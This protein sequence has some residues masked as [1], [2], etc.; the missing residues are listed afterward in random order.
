MGSNLGHF[1]Q[2]STHNPTNTSRSIL[3]KTDSVACD[4]GLLLLEKKHFE[5]FLNFD[6]AKTR[7]EDR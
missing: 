6:P 4:P 5:A 3:M 1:G 7:F 2:I